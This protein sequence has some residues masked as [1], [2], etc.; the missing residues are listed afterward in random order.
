MEMVVSVASDT[1][2][3]CTDAARC[4]ER[5]VRE[6]VMDG[7]AAGVLAGVRRCFAE[8]RDPQVQASC[9]HSLFDIVVHPTILGDGP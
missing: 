8:L 2:K 1:A 3:G 6:R 7:E 4:G 5:G 9:A